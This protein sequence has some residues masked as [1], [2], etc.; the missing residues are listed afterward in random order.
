MDYEIFRGDTWIKTFSLKET[1]GDQIILTNGDKVYFSLKA[2]INDVSYIL[3]KEITSFTN[4]K[5]TI[6]LTHEDTNLLTL[7]EYQYDVQFNYG[8]NVKT[9]KGI[10]KVKGD[11]T[12][13]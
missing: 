9:Q 3:Q 1:S 5:A 4:G 10:F 13:E 7:R 8:S 6:I 11:V 2:N 12:R